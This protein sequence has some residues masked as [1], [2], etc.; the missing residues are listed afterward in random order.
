M[1]SGTEHNALL[2][3]IGALEAALVDAVDE[4]D[5]MNAAWDAQ[6]Q[7]DPAIAS[8]SPAPPT[9]GDECKS[10]DTLMTE[11][12]AATDKAD[13]LAACIAG[14]LEIEIGE[15]TSGNCP[16]QNAFDAAD[17]E[18]GK[19]KKSQCPQQAGEQS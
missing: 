1:T 8:P 9:Q 13:E 11:R 14:L 18:L 3:R 19:R 6:I 7:S 2:D 4:L 15:H 17:Y 16:W 10:C 12:D 5:K